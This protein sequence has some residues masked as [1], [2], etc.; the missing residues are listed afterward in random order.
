MK[1]ITRYNVRLVIAMPLL[2]LKGQVEGA[3]SRSYLQKAHLTEV[4]IAF[5]R[6]T[7]AI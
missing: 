5:G 1:R 2:H 4:Y 7:Q 3:A 6:G